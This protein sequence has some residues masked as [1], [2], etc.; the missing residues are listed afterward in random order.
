MSCSRHRFQQL[1][2]KRD[3]LISYHVLIT[4]T[5]APIALT[6]AIVPFTRTPATISLAGTSSS[7]HLLI[8]RVAVE[9]VAT[10]MMRCLRKMVLT[11]LVVTLLW[12]RWVEVCRLVIGYVYLV[13]DHLE[14]HVIHSESDH[15]SND[16]KRLVYSC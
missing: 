4:F 5:R 10:I 12:W 6:R 8:G 3:Q 13:A 2:T 16:K 14:C 11:P 1:S 9:I 15:D 7:F